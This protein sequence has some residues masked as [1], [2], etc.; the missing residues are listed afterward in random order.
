MHLKKN[1]D[2][3]GEGWV[4]KG[5]FPKFGKTTSQKRG[6]FRKKWIFGV[7]KGSKMGVLKNLVKRGGSTKRNLE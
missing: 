7:E 5:D 1:A 2:F 6:N 4:K 3:L